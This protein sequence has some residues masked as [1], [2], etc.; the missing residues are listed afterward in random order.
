MIHLKNRLVRKRRLIM[1][2]IKLVSL[3]VFVFV[4]ICFAKVS[5]Y[6]IQTLTSL[7]LKNV[8]VAIDSPLTV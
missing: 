6:S 1:I 7:L 5:H 2:H 3:F 4:F 8:S